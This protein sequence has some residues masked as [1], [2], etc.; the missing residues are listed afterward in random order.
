[1]DNSAYDIDLSEK[2]LEGAREAMR[3]LIE[4]RAAN[5]GSLVIRDKDGEIREV[6]A[7]EL[8]ETLPKK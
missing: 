7:K 3:K 5:N 6:P 1:M 4:K 8:L 2:I